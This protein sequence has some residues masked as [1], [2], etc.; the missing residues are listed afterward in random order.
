MSA[1]KLFLT[2]ILL[3]FLATILAPVISNVQ[4]PVREPALSSIV[5]ESRT[6]PTVEEGSSGSYVLPFLLMLATL[7][8]V[9]AIAFLYFG[10]DYLK[11]LRLTRRDGRKRKKSQPRPLPPVPEMTRLPPVREVSEY[12]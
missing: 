11:Q 12:R 9:G 1:A 4:D 5:L 7:V 2:L 3:L 10:A 6:T 8:G